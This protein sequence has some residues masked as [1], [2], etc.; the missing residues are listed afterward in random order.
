MLPYALRSTPLVMCASVGVFLIVGTARAQVGQTVKPNV[1]LVVD[2]SGSMDGDVPGSVPE[3]CSGGTQLIDHARCA[4]QSFVNAYGDVTFGLAKFDQVTSDMDCLDGCNMGTQCS[5]GGDS[6]DRLNV[7]VPLDGENQADILEWVDFTCATCDDDM[8]MN[9]ELFPGGETPIAGSLYGAQRYYQGMDPVWSGLP[10]GDPIGDDPL[11]SVFID[12]A[13]CRPYIVILLTDGNESCG[14]DPEAAA[15]ALLNTM[16]NGLNYRIETKPIGFGFTPC[17]DDIE[18]IAHAG[19]TPDDMNPATCEGFYASNEGELAVAISQ[20]IATSLKSELCN[21]QDDD[22]DVLAD[23]DFQDKGNVC[24]N[25]LQGECYAEGVLECSADQLG[26]SCAITNSFPMPGVIEETCNNLDD[27][28]DGRLDEAPAMCQGCTDGEICDGMDNDCD[29]MVDEGLVR[30]CGT[31]LGECSAGTETCMD[32]NWVGCTEVGPSPEVCDGMDNDCNG[33]VDGFSQ[34]CSNLPGGN[35]G[36]GICQP[37][38]QTCASDGTGFGQCLL[39]VEPAEDNNCDGL[40]DDCDGNVDEHYTPVVCNDSCGQSMTVCANGVLTCP[41]TQVPEAEVCD[42][43][44]NDCDNITDEGIPDNGQCDGGGVLVCEPGVLRC[45]DG[46][47]QCTGGLP[48]TQEVCD[49]SDN[50]CDGSTDEEPPEGICAGNQECVNCTCASPCLPGEFPC[51]AGQQCVEGFCVPNP[52]FTIDCPPVDGVQQECVE[53]MTGTMG[54]CVDSCSLI[55]CPVG[56]VCRPSDGTCQ[57]DNCVA[58]PERC[59]EGEVCINEECVSDPCLGIECTNAGEYCFDGNCVTAC[60]EVDC[61]DGQTC[62]LGVCEADPCGGPCQVA[63]EVCNAGSGVCGPDLCADANCPDGRYCD[64]RNGICQ[65]DVCVV[66][67]CPDEGHVC[68]EG[69]CDFPPP[70][71]QDPPDVVTPGGG[72]GCSAP[73]SGLTGGLAPIMLLLLLVGM[74]T[75]RRRRSAVEDVR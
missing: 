13:Q 62:V 12:G 32:G 69:S 41:A 53:D 42:G 4:I 55:E 6:P 60:S 39:E 19:G 67:D 40:D 71:I 57:P 28:C 17:D 9:P 56:L 3:S 15:T 24:N 16:Y 44:D 14:G 18:A 59:E 43:M 37:G 51:V 20:I 70:P 47:F 2:V 73:S 65:P 75:F 46:S 64:P 61:P 49:C 66:V 58:F 31:D 30:D 23:E 21:E 33:V 38:I 35:P 7:A 45:L 11:N 27:D 54:M 22:C 8:V 34:A 63:G 50:D 1:L 26:L 25:G 74:W 29:M 68:F 36:I 10:G 5:M 72:L 48:G 52:C